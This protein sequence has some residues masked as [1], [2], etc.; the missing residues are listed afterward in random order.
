MVVFEKFLVFVSHIA[1]KAGK[2]AQLLHIYGR[3]INTGQAVEN[4]SVTV[5]NVGD[6]VAVQSSCQSVTRPEIDG[7]GWH[8]ADTFPGGLE[9]GIDVA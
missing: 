3:L 2:L 6:Y 5:A 1:S 9:I 7:Y 4:F 8:R